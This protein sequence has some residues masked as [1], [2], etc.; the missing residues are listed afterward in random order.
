[1][2]IRNK[3]VVNQV[4]GFEW[5]Y[6]ADEQTAKDWFGRRY[7][8]HGLIRC[9]YCQLNPVKFESW[10]SDHT[11]VDCQEEIARLENRVHQYYQIG[12]REGVEHGI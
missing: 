2:E 5:D 1:M 3:K 7:L 9:G 10:Q 11:C 6:E 8:G 4:D 12:K